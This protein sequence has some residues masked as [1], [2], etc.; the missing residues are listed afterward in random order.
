[1]K[2]AGPSGGLGRGEGKAKSRGGFVTAPA[3]KPALKRGDRRLLYFVGLLFGSEGA[4]SVPLSS[5]LETSEIAGSHTWHRS[6][7]AGHGHQADAVA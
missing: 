3:C 1:M 4:G 2:G 6:R 5:P 7:E